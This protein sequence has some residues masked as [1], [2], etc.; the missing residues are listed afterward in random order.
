[1]IAVD[2]S[3]YGSALDTLMFNYTEWQRDGLRM[4]N[5]EEVRRAHAV[6]FE[7]DGV[8]SFVHERKPREYGSG[9]G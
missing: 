7:G 5:V 8:F 2:E 3:D 9:V 4:V 1:M 6:L